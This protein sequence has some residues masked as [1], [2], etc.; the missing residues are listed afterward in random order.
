MSTPSRILSIK[1]LEVWY[2]VYG[3]HLKVVDGIDL[4]VAAGEKVGLV[5]ETGSGKTTTMKAVMRLLPIQARIPGGEILFMGNDVLLMG[6]RKLAQYRSS[7]VSMIF[8]DPTASLNPVFRVGSQLGA[9]IRS[10][11]KG[12][13]SLSFG[14]SAKT[15]ELHDR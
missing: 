1:N 3:G 4:D 15:A 2:K 5:G 9:A 10:S 6:R 7:G 13:S 14:S 12:S 11:M 8:Q